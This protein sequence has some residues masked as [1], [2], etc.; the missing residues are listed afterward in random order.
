MMRAALPAA[1]VLALLSL[2]A[3]VPAIPQEAEDLIDE[4]KLHS[5]SH[6]A[7]VAW[8]SQ[9]GKN[10][11]GTEHD[12]R[13]SV[14][15]ANVDFI[16]EHNRLYEEGKETFYMAVNAFADLT[17]EEF[18]KTRLGY[19][20]ELKPVRSS[21]PGGH[22]SKCTH[23][24]N[25][26][27]PPKHVDW[28]TKG[29]VSEVKNQGQCGSCWSFST[30]G[31]VEGS[32]K[33]SGH[34]LVSL[35][36]EELVQCDTRSD[37]GCNGGLMDNAYEWIINNGGI[38]SETV[39][40]YISGN[41]TT[42]ICNQVHLRSSVAKISDWCDLNKGDEHDLELALAQQPI[43]VA[44]EADQTSFQFYHGGVLPAI[45]CGT[46]LDHGVLAVGYGYSRRHK[47]HYWIVKNSWGATW[48]RKGYILLEKDPKARKGHKV[49]KHSTCGIANAASYPV[50]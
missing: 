20:P 22:G 33:V 7:F 12:S 14:F 41:G 44:I 26:T 9:H 11:E 45:K 6:E 39:Y 49:P 19:N 42:G 35:S 21:G 13:F 17:A 50:V 15:K 47:M 27:A 16:N 2:A 5:G 18:K 28:R 24:N 38:T 36:E 23:R 10:Y 43:A 46:K 31:A 40:P 48:G 25:E 8:K 3:A 29:A 1:L 32:W 37:Q 30:T 34:P 4:I